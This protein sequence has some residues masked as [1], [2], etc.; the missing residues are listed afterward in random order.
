MGSA[1]VSVIIPAYNSGP[2]LTET[3]ESVLRQTYPHREIIVVDD[4]S[5][6][7]TPARAAAYAP[8]VTCIRQGRCGVGTAR[9]RGLASARGDYVALLDHDDLWA[10][11]KLAV[12]VE[13]AARHPASGMVVCDGVEFDGE[14]ILSPHLL[15]RV[16]RDALA[17][18]PAGEVTRHVYREIVQGAA[19]RCPAQTLIPRPVTRRV[20]S[21]STAPEEATDLDYY[22]RIAREYPVTFHRH[23]L[24]RWRYLPTSRSGPS[25]RRTLRWG[26][27]A[28]PVFARQARLAPAEDR[29]V[30]R[31]ALRTFVRRLAREAYYYGRRHELAYARASLW[32]LIRHAPLDARALV[33]LAALSLPEG[34]VGLTVRAARALV[35]TIRRG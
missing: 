12:Q 5:T 10:P 23:S 24:V 9:N 35:R 7:D 2:Y 14:T 19:I 25:E 1:F 30:V 21:L 20:G 27:L 3:I 26:T 13:V 15:D 16:F 32:V 11:E 34:L 22:L 4:G 29:T 31:A 17:Q 6:D 28:A 8:A 18:V 33:Y